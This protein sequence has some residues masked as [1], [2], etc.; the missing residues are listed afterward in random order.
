[1]LEFV[2]LALFISTLEMELGDSMM[3]TACT[4]LLESAGVLGTLL[5]SPIVPPLV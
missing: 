3:L 4:V 2:L 1:M 5:V